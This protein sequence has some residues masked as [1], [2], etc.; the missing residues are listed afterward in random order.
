MRNASVAR[1]IDRIN[2]LPDGL[3]KEINA[4]LRAQ[5]IELGGS[6][7]LAVP[8]DTGAL[9]ESI[10]YEMQTLRAFVRA[11]GASTMKAVRRSAKG[12]APL[13]DYAAYVEFGTARTPAQP[14]FFPT[15]RRKKKAIKKAI[16]DRVKRAVAKYGAGS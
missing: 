7:K 4:E 12:S 5:A 2:R 16:A 3:K 14:F 15:Y 1:F 10:V 11:G 6:M 8:A 13:V 9:R